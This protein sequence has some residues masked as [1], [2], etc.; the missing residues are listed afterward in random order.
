MNS[1]KNATISGGA[2]VERIAAFEPSHL[3]SS[4]IAAVQVSSIFAKPN[5]YRA[6]DLHQ[7][8]AIPISLGLGLGESRFIPL[9]TPVIIKFLTFPT[10]YQV[11]FQIA[12][13]FK[14]CTFKIW[15]FVDI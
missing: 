7:A 1:I 10:N 4:A 8:I 12:K 14:D 5:W 15:E 6:G 11:S 2:I 9:Y 13:Y 3:F